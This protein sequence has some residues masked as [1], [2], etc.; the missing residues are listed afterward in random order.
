VFVKSATASAAVEEVF[1]AGFWD[2]FLPIFDYVVGDKGIKQADSDAS[3]CD[4]D[5]AVIS[6]RG[7]TWLLGAGNQSV[8]LFA[9]EKKKSSVESGREMRFAFYGLVQKAAIVLSVLF[10]AL[11]VCTAVQSINPF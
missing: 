1:E 7:D 5:L 8:F 4:R 10:L 9:A 2:D 11:T 3:L 6:T